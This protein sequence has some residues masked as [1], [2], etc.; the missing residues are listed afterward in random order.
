MI[1]ISGI[2]TLSMGILMIAVWIV[3]LALGK[4]PELKTVPFEATFLLIAESLTAI[5][6]LLGGA[7]IL[8]KQ[9]WGKKLNLTAMGMMLY[10]VINSIG[11]FGQDGIIPLVIFFIILT[12][13]T[14]F[15]L[16]RSTVTDNRSDD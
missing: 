10:T 9:K 7:G 3:Y 14:I 4:F 1:K 12:L 6:L 15:F 16:I 11:V 13:L 2:F 5:A 8:K